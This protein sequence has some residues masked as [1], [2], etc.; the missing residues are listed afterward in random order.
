M[1]NTNEHTVENRRKYQNPATI[2]WI[3]GKKIW[4]INFENLIAA[5]EFCDLITITC[6]NMTFMSL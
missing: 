6:E 3:S 2:Y 1:K 5:S 4:I